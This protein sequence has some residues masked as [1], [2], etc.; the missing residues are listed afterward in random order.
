LRRCCR[1]RHA[2]VV[3]D[4]HRVLALACRRRPE[5]I[6]SKRLNGPYV[7]GASAAESR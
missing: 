5:G 4:E 1:A 6:V 2:L 7:S 3:V